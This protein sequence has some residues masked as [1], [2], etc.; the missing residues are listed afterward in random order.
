MGTAAVNK[1]T[2]R[3][4]REAKGLTSHAAAEALAPLL[5][6]SSYDFSSVLKA[7]ID[8]VFDARVLNA[9][10]I[11]YDQPIR[12]VMKAVGIEADIL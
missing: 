4:M 12:M 1:M 11:L 9:Y 3:E 7:E 5:G 6:R 10:S 2:L 8:G